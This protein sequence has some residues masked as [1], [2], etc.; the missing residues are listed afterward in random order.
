VRLAGFECKTRETTAVVPFEELRLLRNRPGEKA[1]A[2]RAVRNEPNSELFQRRQYFLF[3]APPPERV[4]TLNRG[5]RLNGV[6]S[7]DCLRASL[8]QAEVLHLSYLNQVLHCS[9]YIFDRHLGIDSVLIEQVDRI[10][11]KPLH[12]ALHAL[13]DV[14]GTTVETGGRSA[15]AI[16]C[17]PELRRDCHLVPHG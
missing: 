10:D 16:Q 11:P 5:Y 7:S 4:F 13:L 2:K 3:R 8:R 1:P 17:K 14:V 12:R 9:C 6:C 15:M